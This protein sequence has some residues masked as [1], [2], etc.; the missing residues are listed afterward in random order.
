[1]NKTR[2]RALKH[3]NVE[4]QSIVGQLQDEASHKDRNERREYRIEV[5][6]AN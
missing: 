4:A 1:M 5:E 2:T 6:L 3:V